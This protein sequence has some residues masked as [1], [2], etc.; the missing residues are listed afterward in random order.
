MQGGKQTRLQRRSA[1]SPMR[2]LTRGPTW[3]RLCACLPAAE[4]CRRD[5][6][7]AYA[8]LPRPRHK[9]GKGSAV[10]R[11]EGLH[12]VRRGKLHRRV[13]RAQGYSQSVARLRAAMAWVCLRMGYF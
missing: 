3:A 4:T 5:A 9:V 1:V 12:A 13:R 6:Y 2:P 11:H 8:W 7:P 10:N